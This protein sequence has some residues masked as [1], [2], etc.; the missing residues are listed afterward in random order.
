MRGEPAIRTPRVEERVAVRYLSATRHAAK[1][2]LQPW[3]CKHFVSKDYESIMNIVL[4]YSRGDAI[5]V[6]RSHA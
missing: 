1:N 3:V 2:R 6:S 5:Q 4:G